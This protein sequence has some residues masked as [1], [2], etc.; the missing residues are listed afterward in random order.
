[1]NRTAACIAL[2]LLWAVGPITAQQHESGD[3]HASLKHHQLSLFT[4]YTWVP[5]GDPHE[6][7]SEGTVIAPTVGVDY[8]YWFSHKFGL[9]LYND[10]ELTSYVV[11]TSAD[12]LIPREYAYVG[13]LVGIYEPVRGLGLYGGPGVELEEHHNFFV[14]KVGLEYA[15]A[16]TDDW[17]TGFALGYDFKEE[18]DSWA[19]GVSVGRK[20]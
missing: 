7:D 6:G 8:S 18:Y 9:G 16:I 15:F 12:T 13:A 20:F 4:G 1:M 10:F 17:V 11:E 5:K 14:L 19:A 3:E 2:T